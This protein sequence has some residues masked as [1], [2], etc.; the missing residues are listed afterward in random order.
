[1]NV[2]DCVVDNE[3]AYSETAIRLVHDTPF[4]DSV[5]AQITEK[6]QTLFGDVSAID[7][8]SDVFETLIKDSR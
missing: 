2:M 1:M 5:R 8:I 3:E 7:E 6:A 4:R